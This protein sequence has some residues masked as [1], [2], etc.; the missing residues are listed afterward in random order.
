MQRNIAEP[1][2]TS[3]NAEPKYIL[4]QSIINKEINNSNKTTS[5]I[6]ITS[7]RT[8]SHTP[9]IPFSVS[10][11]NDE[12]M[13]IDNIVDT[14]STSPVHNIN[15]L[16]ANTSAGIQNSVV[17]DS[18]KSSQN[19]ND[20]NPKLKQYLGKIKTL[21]Q[22]LRRKSKKINELNDTI[23]VFKNSSLSIAA[24]TPAI[25]LKR[26][27]KHKPQRK[28]AM[29]PEILD[30]IHKR[31]L[32]SDQ[33]NEII[34]HCTDGHHHKIN[35]YLVS[36]NSK[37]SPK[38]YQPET[39]TFSVTLNI[40]APK[41]YKFICEHFTN[42]LPRPT[43]IHAWYKS[44][45]CKPG[46]TNEAFTAISMAVKEAE[47]RNQIIFINLSFDE[48]PIRNDDSSYV[49]FGG[50]TNFC[51]I[52]ATHVFVFMAVCINRSWK[53]PLGYFAINYMDA[54][55]KSN[56]IKL[57]IK[58][59]LETG[60]EIVGL[61]VDGSFTNL[62]SIKNLGCD[63]WDQQKSDYA[64]CLNSDTRFVITPDPVHMLKLVHDAFR[65]IRVF[66]DWKYNKIEWNYLKLLLEL[67]Q[68]EQMYLGNKLR[69]VF[70]NYSYSNMIVN[71]DVQCLSKSVADALDFCR[72]DLQLPQFGNSKATATFIRHLNDI[73]DILNSRKVNATGYQKP[74]CC[75]NI[76]NL[77][78]FIEIMVGYISGLKSED[79]QELIHLHKHKTGFIGTI[80]GL[81]NIKLFYYRFI[82]NAP[83]KYIPLYKCTQTHLRLFLSKIRNAYAHKPTIAEFRSAYTKLISRIKLPVN[84][85]DF[86]VFLEDMGILKDASID[87]IKEIN[88][89]VER[90]IMIRSV[91]TD[92][93]ETEQI[94]NEY[95]HLFNVTDSLYK[96]YV[97]KFIAAFVVFKLN[98]DLKCAICIESLLGEVTA[99]TLISY[100]SKGF[101]IYPSESVILICEIADRE[102]TMECSKNLN[103]IEMLTVRIL[104]RLVSRDLFKN[105]L[106]HFINNNHYSLIIKSIVINYLNI[107]YFFVEKQISNGKSF[108]EKY[109]QIM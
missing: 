81:K 68:V 52:P 51:N 54:T 29:L 106:S 94:L 66:F 90:F 78:E 75:E 43:N 89:S 100:E 9:F 20:T 40:L 24:Q 44:F 102:F 28:K 61:T 19:K 17:D 71:L 2:I 108:Q 82:S 103:N 48:M 30:T 49:D 104:G 83:L 73:S 31:N 70:H 79:G 46:F 23:N 25:V 53:I 77:N 98:T 34:K 16:N 63:L 42:C 86:C 91:N 80:A 22:S 26:L 38:E 99:T 27:S 5:P 33:V 37:E 93:L 97:I 101:L 6:I 84:G 47:T 32:V 109:K 62:T 65:D 105:S 76:D 4:P 64:F 12:P 45:D 59:L 88:T 58:N 107:K 72:E 57:C 1:L 85:I 14:A 18:L 56:L 55:Q 36:F 7:V 69:K 60:V 8:L 74:M 21:Q 3:L 35:K 95:S 41:A 50:G 10:S 96:S 13:E 11:Q 15:S 87:P 92:D 39:Q 67:E